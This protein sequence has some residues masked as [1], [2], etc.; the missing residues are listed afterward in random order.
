MDL[1][2]ILQDK[3]KDFCEDLSSE[4]LQDLCFYLGSGVNSNEKPT[5]I[6]QKFCEDFLGAV[7]YAEYL[8]YTAYPKDKKPTFSTA[9]KTGMDI[10]ELYSYISWQAIKRMSNLF[11]EISD[12]K[13]KTS[14]LEVKV[15]SQE[16]KKAK[17][18]KDLSTAIVNS[19][20]GDIFYKDN[21]WC[22][23]SEVLEE[24]KLIKLDL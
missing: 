22:N 21:G 18:K 14:K 5:E 7:N 16:L 3:C 4:E 17:L 8:R 10:M 20:E 24:Y 13:V 15:A 2:L 23:I 19:F 6:Q 1:K 9:H 11:L 12:L